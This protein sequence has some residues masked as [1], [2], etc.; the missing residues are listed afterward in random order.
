[1]SFFSERLED[2]AADIRLFK[3]ILNSVHVEYF[4]ISFENFLCW[5]YSKIYGKKSLKIFKYCQMKSNKEVDIQD[6][7]KLYINI[8]KTH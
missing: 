8:Y 3:E 1:M 2:K 7:T 6:Q 4:E 5:V